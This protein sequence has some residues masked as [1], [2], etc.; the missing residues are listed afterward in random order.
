MEDARDRSLAADGADLRSGLVDPVEELEDVSLRTLVLVDG[1]PRRRIVASSDAAVALFQR[2]LV[3]RSAL[4]RRETGGAALPSAPSTRDGAQPKPRPALRGGTTQPPYLGFAVHGR[5]LMLRGAR[6]NPGTA[7]MKKM[8]VCTL[9]DLL[10]DAV[11]KL[12]RPLAEGDDT[13]AETRVGGGG[14]AANVAAWAAALGA[15]S[16]RRQAWSGC[17]RR[18]RGGRPASTRRGRPRAPPTGRNGVVV[19]LVELDGSRTMISDRGVAPE[20]APDE[21]EEVVR[22]GGLAPPVG[23]LADARADRSRGRARRRARPL[24]RRGSASTSPP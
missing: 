1:Q 20:L 12:A 17:G 14:Q 18:G 2:L 19:S 11:V 22:P 8:V 10:L 6:I 3:A 15:G 9:G 21:L 13:R 7:I 5:N 16:V 4:E 24:A 23:L